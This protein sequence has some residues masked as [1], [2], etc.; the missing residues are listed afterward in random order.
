MERF[1][2]T[3]KTEWVMHCTY[4]TRDEAR[5]SLFDYIEVFFNR[6]R[7]HSSIRYEALHCRSRRRI[8][9]VRCPSF[10]GKIVDAEPLYQIADLHSR[11]DP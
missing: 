11:N 2:Y 5:A 10:V 4:Q 1:F 6:Q 7:R 8:R 3:L 9:L